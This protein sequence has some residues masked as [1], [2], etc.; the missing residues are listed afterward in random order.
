MKDPRRFFVRGYE[1]FRQDRQNRRKEE[2][3][4][5]VRNSIIAVETNRSNNQDLEHITVK[6]LLPSGDLWIT[7]CYSPPTSSLA[8]HNVKLE[9]SRHLVAGDFNSHS[10]SWGYEEMDARGKEVEDW[11]MENNLVL[12]NQAEDKSNAFP[13]PGKLPPHQ[14]WQ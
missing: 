14:T 7:N 1:S 6:L 10:Q 8:L 2:I 5:L 3:I 4:S 12:I 9:A 13:E 11:M